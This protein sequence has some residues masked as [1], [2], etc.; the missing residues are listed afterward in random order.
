M[1]LKTTK[2]LTPILASAILCGC[3]TGGNGINQP[4]S[5][6]A[7]TQDGPLSYQAVAARLG[8]INQPI[9]LTAVVEGIEINGAK[10]GAVDRAFGIIAPQLPA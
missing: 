4:M 1:K 2:L 9:V 3:G 8:P 6:A 10:T 5:A 7:I